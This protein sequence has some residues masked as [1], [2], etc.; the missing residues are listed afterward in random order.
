[1]KIIIFM[2]QTEDW[3]KVTWDTL[4]PPWTDVS[5]IDLKYRFPWDRAFNVPYFEYR[6]R[7]KEIAMSAWT[8]DFIHCN[9]KKLANKINNDDYVIPSDDDDWFNPAIEDFLLNSVEEFVSWDS[10]VNKMAYRFGVVPHKKFN[11]DIYL[12]TNGYAIK[13]SV[14]KRASGEQ[15][16]KMLMSHT[17]TDKVIQEL[18]CS[19]L[20]RKDLFLALYNW[21]IGSMTALIGIQDPLKIMGLLP[22]NDPVELPK[23][24]E[25]AE[26]QFSQAIELVQ[27]L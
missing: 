6:R 9:P 10:V 20:D 3:A 8:L 5:K 7:L 25:W 26:P 4:K 11:K 2:R 24:W 12:P 1:M 13:G 23:R 27:S 22:K 17:H 19:V 21:H 18:G 16:W 14:I 15:Q